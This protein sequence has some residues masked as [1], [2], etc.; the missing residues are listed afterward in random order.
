MTVLHLASRSPLESRALSNCLDRLGEGDAVLLLADG[1]Y[2]VVSEAGIGLLL[3]IRAKHCQCHV[4][5]PDLEARGLVAA[6]LPAE[7]SP[8][9]Y[10]GFVALTL[11]HRHILTW[12]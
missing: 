10:P 9:D 12:C 6:G 11:E 2:A 5:L 3:Q 1:V 4:L 8:V 7:I